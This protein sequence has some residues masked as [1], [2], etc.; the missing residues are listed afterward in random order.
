[1]PI[2]VDPIRVERVSADDA[3]WKRD[4]DRFTR[5]VAAALEEANSRI[6]SLE[7]RVN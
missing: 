2:P 1:M 5:D 7:S 6:K 3:Q 4:V